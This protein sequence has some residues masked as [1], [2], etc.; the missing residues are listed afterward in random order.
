MRIRFEYPVKTSLRLKELWPVTV[1][2]VKLEWRMQDDL[3]VALIA[4]CA[5]SEKDRLPTVTRIA[6]G[7]VAAN[8]D[9]GHI[10]RHD[11]VERIARTVQG[12]V[13]LFVTIDIDFDECKISWEPESDEEKKQLQLKEFKVGTETL[14]IWAP[15]HLSYEFIARAML[16]ADEVADQEVTLAFLRRGSRD[17]HS[18]DCILAF[19]NFFFFLETQFAPGYSDPKRVTEKFLKAEPIKRAL[20]QLRS[21]EA[22]AELRGPSAKLL[23]KSDEELIKH[24]VKTRGELHHHAQ[25][26]P[27]VWHPDKPNAVV[28]EVEVLQ[29]I[30]HTIAFQDSL[31][32]MYKE[33][34]KAKLRASAEADGAIIT[35]KVVGYGIRKDGTKVSLVPTVVTTPGRVIDHAKVEWVHNHIRTNNQYNRN[36]VELVEYTICSEDERQIFARWRRMDPGAPPNAHIPHNG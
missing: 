23:K 32:A 5:M 25:R 17:L 36:D 26:R 12:L 10:G 22:Q 13:S 29:A 24:L 35:I 31:A 20:A 2:G 33:D 14:D 7:P 4:S 30:A 16:S 28:A 27:G 18:G 8:I 34:K 19:Y 6:K 3:P 9:V 1:T 21:G 15:R 11:E